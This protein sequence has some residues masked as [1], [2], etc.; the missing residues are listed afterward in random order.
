MEL[1]IKIIIALYVLKLF[2]YGGEYNVVKH[3]K[4]GKEYLGKYILWLSKKP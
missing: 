2:V 1:T 3:I 4:Q